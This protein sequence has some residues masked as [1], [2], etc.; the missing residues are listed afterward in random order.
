[1][2]IFRQ[3]YDD[4]FNMYGPQGWW[5]LLSLHM[6]NK[7]INPTKTGSIKGYH[8]NDYSFPKNNLER[9][10][11]I[12][13]ALLTQ[14]TSWQSVEKSLFNLY[15][16][17][18][19]YPELILKSDIDDIKELIKP[20]GYFN[21]KAERLV[22]LAKWFLNLRGVPLRDELLKLKGVGPETADSILLYAFKMPEFVVDSYT[23]RIFLN[24]GLININD[25]YEIVKDFFMTNLDFD[26]KLFNEYHALIVEH[27]KRYY[28]KKENY[29]NCPLYL[30]YNKKN[31]KDNY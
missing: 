19:F 20:S 28:F 24:L 10:E 2:N 27:A 25:K 23:R 26:Y 3:I 12:M 11:I 8:P 4:L 5:P 15:N 22:L 18:K 17:N 16:N 7:G 6:N 30:N 31:I 21:Q 13:G 9:W 29:S 14:N 1:M